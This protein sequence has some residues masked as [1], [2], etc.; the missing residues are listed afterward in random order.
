MHFK[1]VDEEEWE[2]RLNA[3][4]P[5]SPY[6]GTANPPIPERLKAHHVR[7]CLMARGDA[8]PYARG[9]STDCSRSSIVRRKRR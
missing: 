3:M 4:S 6:E 5:N 7:A 9:V 1:I 2:R 8:R